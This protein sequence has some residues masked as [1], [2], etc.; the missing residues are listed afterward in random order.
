[1]KFIIPALGASP[2]ASSPLHASKPAQMP[3]TPA[4][5][6]K[7][8]NGAARQPKPVKRAEPE[9]APGEPVPPAKTDEPP[10]EPAKAKEMDWHEAIVAEDNDALRKALAK[11]IGEIVSKHKMEHYD[12]LLLFDEADS[13]STYHSDRLYAAASETKGNKKDILLIVQSHGGRI[14]PA[15]LI[16]KTLKRLSANKFVAV[17]PRRAKSAATLI[18][19]G[20]DEIHMGMMSQLGP[21]DPQLYGLPAMSLANALDFIADLSCRFPAASELLTKYLQDQAPIRILGYHQRVNESA[22]QYAERLLAGKA[23]ADGKT[24]EQVAKHLVNHYKDHDFVIDSDEATTLL[25]DG[26]VKQG[27]SEYQCADE[28]YRLLDLVGIFLSIRDKQY[29]YV[30][31]IDGGFTTSKKPSGR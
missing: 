31:K 3:G 29:W 2:V 25:G 22:V 19:L 18:A 16:S 4:P 7:P 8:E 30:G 15:Y 5:S 9:K 10:K 6:T 1:M 14:E 13:I 26:I 21:I 12:V 24:P 28:I 20:A 27:T 11:E 23:L 17:V